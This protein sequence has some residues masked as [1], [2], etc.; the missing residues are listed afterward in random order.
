VSTDS[1]LGGSDAADASTVVPPLVA[2]PLFVDQVD[3]AVVGDVFAD[4]SEAQPD[5]LLRA[6]SDFASVYVRH[7]SALQL[8][9]R[10]FLNDAHD[11]EDAVQETFIKLFLAMPEIETELQALAFSR[12]VLTNLCIDRYRAAQ[13]R[14]AIVDLDLDFLEEFKALES[15]TDPVVQAEDA[16][17]VRQALAMLSPLHR[18]ALVKREIEEKPLPVIAAELG[19]PEE[20]VKHLLYRARRALRRLLAGSAVDPG[21][22]LSNREMLAAANRRIGRGA[23]GAGQYVVV[24]LV[25]L[26]LGVVVTR[27]GSPTRSVVATPSGEATTAP[28]AGGAQPAITGPGPGTLRARAGGPGT[29]HRPAAPGPVLTPTAPAVAQP[30]PTGQP[31][32][33]GSS[34]GRSPRKPPKVVAVPAAPVSATK[35]YSLT[36][37]LTPLTTPTIENQTLLPVTDP[38]SSTLTSAFVT[39]TTQGNFEIDQSVSQVPGQEPTVTFDTQLPVAGQSLQTVPLAYASSAQQLPDGDRKLTGLVDVALAPQGL[40]QAALLPDLQ[41]TQVAVALVM[42]PDLSRV[43]SESVNV[44][45]V[46]TTIPMPD[47]SP[48]SPSPAPSASTQAVANWVETVP[49]APNGEGNPTP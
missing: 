44:E 18:A 45:N 19:V 16:A 29:S 3:E 40:G 21:A 24:I 41:P 23:L 30:A 20:S 34:S 26:A 11:V 35:L 4:A 28:A 13:R 36:G 1:A 12:R 22:D 39:P 6:P 33:G 15:P 9:A 25:F 32:P 49:D 47:P 43:V 48:T 38:G 17:V 7:R 42:S 5:R 8:H 27:P 37:D 10:R 31:R 46:P 14:P 2:D